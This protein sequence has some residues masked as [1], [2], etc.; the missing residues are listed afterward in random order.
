[1][2]LNIGR[3]FD[4]NRPWWSLGYTLA[5]ATMIG[6]PASV[7]LA[8]RANL[9]AGVISSADGLLIAMS[10]IGE[11]LTFAALLQAGSRP[12]TNDAP[13]GPLTVAVYAVASGLVSLPLFLL[14]S[15]G[16]AFAP[17]LIP[18]S[19]AV[20][21]PAFGLSGFV[22]FALPIALAVALVW[23]TRDQPIQPRFDLSGLI[24]LDWLYGLA[25]HVVNLAARVSN[26]LASLLEGEGS[27]VWA[28]LILIAAY[29]VLVGAVP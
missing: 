10:L 12:A 29:V 25:F 6:A 2:T 21:L 4:R 9:M 22:M 23:T 3:G 24:S 8:A 28:L 16:R 1:M 17:E 27:M 26:G 20:V 15:F 18:P 11:T 19:F 7:G 5:F 14:P 13:T